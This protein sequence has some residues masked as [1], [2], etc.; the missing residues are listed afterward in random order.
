MVVIKKIFIYIFFF[1]FIFCK[2]SYASKILDYETEIFLKSLI[3][4]IIQANDI[5]RNIRFAVLAN[6]NVNAFVDQNSIIYITSGLIENCNDYVALL[7]VIAHEIGHIDNN[8]IKQREIGLKKIK[9]INSISNL[10]II[11]G[12]LISKN[13]EILQTLTLSS[14]TTSDYF[15]NFSKD[16]EREADYY[17]LNTLKKLNLYSTSIIDLLKTIEKNSL[18]KGITKDRLKISTHPYFEERIDII[19]YLN[20]KKNSNFDFETNNKFKFIKAKFLGYSGN[21]EKIYELEENYERY[22]NSI[23]NAK[24]GNLKLSM[25]ELNKLIKK[26]DNNNIFLYETKADILFSF[27]YID[28]SIKFYKKVI[29]KYGDNYY[30]QIRIF[31]NT[32]IEELTHFEAETLFIENLN[33]I[34]NFYNNKNILLT[35][36]RLSEYNKKTEWINF[37]NYWINKDNNSLNT[38]VNLKKF[39]NAEDKNLSKLVELIYQNTK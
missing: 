1:L 13:P 27:G 33:L 4:E 29:D 28:E 18:S 2:S 26:Y 37:L 9:N 34:N 32:E 21:I 11:A 14:A 23:L 17:A 7:T 20:E 31:E 15:I 10:S 35:Y 19:N 39:K 12:S 5:N 16:Q 3:N 24:D 6:N 8:H 30:A 22:A 38:K 25:E 36:L